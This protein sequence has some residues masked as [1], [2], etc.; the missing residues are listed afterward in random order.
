MINID[1]DVLISLKSFILYLIAIN[2]ITFLTMGIDK[3]KAKRG[4]WRIKESTLFTMVLLGGG[5]G[6]ILGMTVF[7]HKTKKLKFKIGFPLIL[8]FEVVAIIVII[9][10]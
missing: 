5:I 9:I 4:S 2:I 10:Q 1:T 8:I 6:G 7:R 3:W